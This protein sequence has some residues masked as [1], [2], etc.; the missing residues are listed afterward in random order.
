MAIYKTKNYRI[1]QG[2]GYDGCIPKTVYW[3]QKRED[4]FFAD[5]WRYIK[6][7]TSYKKAKELLDLLES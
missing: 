4:G 3:V 7:F 1:I 2:D 6:G 5:N